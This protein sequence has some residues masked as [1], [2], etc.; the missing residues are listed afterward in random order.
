MS[1]VT[2]SSAR[3]D[4]AAVTGALA[5]IQQSLRVD[6]YRLDVDSATVADLRVTIA[7]LEGACE[8]CLAPPDVLKMIIS[9]GLDGAYRPEEIDLRLP[10]PKG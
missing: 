6:G 9:A 5:E 2:A 4:R 8:E 10:T 7:A 3:G 1:L